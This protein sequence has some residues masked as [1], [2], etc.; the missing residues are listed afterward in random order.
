VTYAEL[1]RALIYVLKVPPDRALALDAEIKNL[2]HHGIPYLRR[3]A[4]KGKAIDYGYEDV[5][6]LM[7]TLVLCSWRSRPR[8]MSAAVLRHW[9]A[10]AEGI[11]R[12]HASECMMLVAKPNF[13]TAKWQGRDPMPMQ[14]MP[15]EEVSERWVEFVR[16]D[17]WNEFVWLSTYLNLLE[18]GLTRLRARVQKSAPQ[19]P[20]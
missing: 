17:R 10:I 6:M 15:L 2:S 19:S 18:E 20:R 4:Q 8:D 1:R 3:P 12:H 9:P 16:D 13:L 11:R 14:C 5:C 7:L